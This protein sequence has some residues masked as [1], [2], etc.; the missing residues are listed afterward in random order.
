MKKAVLMALILV[1]LLAACSGSATSLMGPTWTVTS[2]TGVG[3]D[4]TV[5]ITAVFGSDGKI[6]GSGG[7][8]NYTAAYTVDGS[9]ITIESPAA[10]QMACAEIANQ[11]ESEYFYLLEGTG[12]YEIRGDKLTI[13]DSSGQTTIEYTSGS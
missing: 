13:K 3:V 4:P 12:T 10:T 2:L 7:C 8:N 11:Q 1:A 9:S 5:T 6:T